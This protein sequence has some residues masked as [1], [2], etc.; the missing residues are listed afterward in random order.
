MSTFTV[1]H[2]AYESDGITALYD[3]DKLVVEG[4]YYHDKIDSLIEGF[5]L[6][7]DH[8]KIE[9][10]RADIYISDEHYDVV[11]GPEDVS[12]SL[13][14]LKATYPWTADPE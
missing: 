12:E 13:T 11:Y 7:L 14:A 3:D 4:D 8:V 10:E 5:F 1:V 2:I 9:Y 6:G